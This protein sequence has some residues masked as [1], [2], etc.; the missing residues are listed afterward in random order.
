VKPLKR[1]FISLSQVEATAASVQGARNQQNQDAYLMLEQHGVFAVCDGMGGH[2]GGQV[3]SQLII[4]TIRDN[5]KNVTIDTITVDY[6]INL[7]D[8]ANRAVYQHAQQHLQLRGMGTTLVL[9]WIV[10]TQLTVY[11][12]GDSRAY[13]LRADRLKCLTQ[14]HS[15]SS[16]K[17]VN[18][19][20]G[21]KKTVDIEQHVWD[22]K[23]GD[24]LLLVS[25][26]ISNMLPDIQLAHLLVKTPGPMVIQTAQLIAAA[27]EVGGDDDKTVVLVRSS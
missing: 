27:R 20:L 11:H 16:G 15:P 24:R 9:A 25:D 6:L 21:V 19:A 23:S 12:V 18:R 8:Y 17:G 13:R 26:G 2:A 22:W 14:D 1:Q 3:A 10:D 4:H 5:L 7:I